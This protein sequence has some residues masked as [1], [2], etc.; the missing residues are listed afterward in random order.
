MQMMRDKLSDSPVLLLDDV[1]SELDHE[2]QR[3]LTE[4]ISSSQTI[5]TCTGV[6]DSLKNLHAE[7]IL[8]VEKG[9]VRCE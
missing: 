9:E 1:M 2:R 8:H 5:L 3:Q 6:E 4:Y 7:K